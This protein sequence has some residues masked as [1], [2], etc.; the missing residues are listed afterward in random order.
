MERKV[1]L[2]PFCD[3]EQEIEVE[4]NVVRCEKCGGVF[5]TDPYDHEHP[6][7]FWSNPDTSARF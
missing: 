2:C 3:R 6:R 4:K 5:N 1:V 7:E